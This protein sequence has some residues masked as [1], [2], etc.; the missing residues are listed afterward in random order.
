MKKK[1]KNELTDSELNT[2]MYVLKGMTNKEIG[3]ELSIS[4]HTAK[5]HVS[6]ALKKINCKNRLCFVLKA[7]KTGIISLDDINIDDYNRDDNY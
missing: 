2:L 3:E 6:S 4:P 7:L 5:A 1:N